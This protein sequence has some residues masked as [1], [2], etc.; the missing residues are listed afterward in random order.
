[1]S[2]GVSPLPYTVPHDGVVLDPRPNLLR[3][4][5]D[6]LLSKLMTTLPWSHQQVLSVTT[7][8]WVTGAESL[9]KLIYIVPPET[10][11][12]DALSHQEAG[13]SS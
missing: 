12:L 2:W 5:I 6:R 3:V 1:M 13:S 8:A 7:V 11:T 4:T 9:G 10:S